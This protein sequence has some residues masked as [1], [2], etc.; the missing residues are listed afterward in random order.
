[1]LPHAP[2]VTVD[3]DYVLAPA[4]LLAEE[5]PDAAAAL[6]RHLHTEESQL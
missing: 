3:A 6:M 1:L 4:G 2:A 5:H